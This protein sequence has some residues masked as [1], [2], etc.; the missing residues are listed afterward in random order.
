MHPTTCRSHTQHAAESTVKYVATHVWLS[1]SKLHQENDIR[2][3]ED[4]IDNTTSVVAW[5][6]VELETMRISL[7]C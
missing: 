2:S 1:G 7:Q 3:L 4:C 5:P 6:Y